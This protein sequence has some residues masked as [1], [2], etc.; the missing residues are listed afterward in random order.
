MSIT[1]NGINRTEAGALG[2]ASFEETVDILFRCAAAVFPTW[3]RHEPLHMLGAK[4][5][6]CCKERRV[7]VL[8]PYP[9]ALLTR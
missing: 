3:C 4:S 7:F 2:Q 6:L 5:Q 8:T 1:R 9:G